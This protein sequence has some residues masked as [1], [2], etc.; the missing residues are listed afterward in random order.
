MYSLFYVVAL[1]VPK[2]FW[3]HLQAT[4]TKNVTLAHSMK[5]YHQ[6]LQK[7]PDQ[8]PTSHEA[9]LIKIKKNKL[10]HEVLY[11]Q[12]EPLVKFLDDV[13]FSDEGSNCNQF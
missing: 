4:F 7:H 10:L 3:I 9:F 12:E 6:Q 5:E 2:T 13:R 1:A 11:T 8:F